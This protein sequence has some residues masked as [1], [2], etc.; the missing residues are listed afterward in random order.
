MAVSPLP[1]AAINNSST[2]N[3]MRK[4]YL[5]STDS[6]N[7][8]GSGS[9]CESRE[10]SKKQT[11]T[12]QAANHKSIQ[13]AS[14]WPFGEALDESRLQHHD[15]N[16]L[17]E[18][19]EE[20]EEDEE[21][22]LLEGGESSVSS[23]SGG[24]RGAGRDGGILLL[25]PSAANSHLLTRSSQLDISSGDL[26]Q[27]EAR[28]NIKLYHIMS[29]LVKTEQDYVLSLEYIIENYLPELLRDD[30]PQA[31]R[32]QRNVI[33]G[34][35]EKIYE[36]HRGYFLKHLKQCEKKPLD[37]GR[38][39]LKYERQ[40]YLYAL[41]NKNKPKSDTLMAE[42]GSIFFRNKQL[43]IGDKMDLASYLLK[44]VQRMGKYALLL[45]QLVQ[46]SS[47]SEACVELTEAQQMVQF[48]L[49]H[50]N[51]LL[52]M[53]SLKDCDVNLKEQG[54]LLRQGEFQVWEGAR[55]RRTT[56]HVFLFEEL[57][58]F[59]K[60]RK[61][62]EKRNLDIFQYK[63]SIKMT[64]I[65][66]TEQLDTNTKFEIWFRKRKP[67]DTYVL[68]PA[69]MDMKE[70]WTEEIS[71]LL[72]R[73][74]LKNRTLRLHEMSSMGIGNKPCLDIR[75]SEDQISDRSVAVSYK[76]ASRGSAGRLE[77]QMSNNSC[78]SNNNNCDTEQQQQQPQA[79][80]STSGSS[81]DS[82]ATAAGGV[83]GS[84]LRRPYSIISVSSSSSNSSSHPSSSS[85]GVGSG[86]GGGNGVG[87]LFVAGTINLGF[88]PSNSPRPLHRSVTRTSQCS[89]ESGIL[90]DMYPV[91]SSEDGHQ[92]HNSPN[93]SNQ[94]HYR[95][96]RSNSTVTTVSVDSGLSPSIPTSPAIHN[97]SSVA[98][99]QLNSTVTSVNMSNSTSKYH[100]TPS[101]LGANIL[102]SLAGVSL[103][104]S[105][106]KTE[107]IKTLSTCSSDH[108]Q[109][110]TSSM[111]SSGCTSVSSK[112]SS[113][114]SASS[115]S[116]SRT[117]DVRSEKPT[118][119]VPESP[120][121]VKTLL[122]TEV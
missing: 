65:G 75:P 71:K 42:Y 23:P 11:M 116:P 76:Q 58:L 10:G 46:L 14:A 84:S 118:P 90:A 50:G 64:D 35:I 52:A 67:S 29:E 78:S 72:W 94:N 120:P 47:G 89:A 85:C 53:D 49:R 93:N 69:S 99:T 13:R 70:A 107:V 55:G 119:P 16:S 36:F 28:K 104:E 32:G 74:A 80:S 2:N 63:H 121:T 73:Q 4:R 24:A 7:S 6:S 77:S 56:R 15:G 27:E 8:S 62:P 40:F 91:E 115:S 68:Q 109:S 95:V 9:F 41:Y 5:S 82:N 48:Q 25:P 22:E 57:I 1:T 114:S 88:E 87:P 45:T 105:S 66:L 51:D 30:I 19:D 83:G 79:S 97:S 108:P 113:S 110:D 38:I 26:P 117:A 61:D 21:E 112:S 18:D 92:N 54:Q 96:E 86:G 102:S 60:A 122:T 100:Q 37:I 39:F 106:P 111:I 34:N 3:S 103:Y 59:S 98:N 12:R 17:L 101:L 43:E 33:F 20:I 44:P 81:N 31:L